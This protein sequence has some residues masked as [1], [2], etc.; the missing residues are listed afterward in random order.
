MALIINEKQIKIVPQ[1]QQK[2]SI[3][4]NCVLSRIRIEGN[5]FLT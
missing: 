5:N 3:V 1:Q 2:N 4:S